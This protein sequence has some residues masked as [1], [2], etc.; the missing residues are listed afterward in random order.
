MLDVITKLRLQSLQD[1]MST[2]DR[3]DAETYNGLRACVSRNILRIETKAKENVTVNTG[4]L[5]NSI[6]HYQQDLSGYVK[7]FT[8]YAIDV[9]QGQKPGNM[10]SYAAIEYWFIRKNKL[11][12]KNKWDYYPRIQAIREKIYKDGTK[13]QPFLNPAFDGVVETFINECK[14]VANGA[15]D[16]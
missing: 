9:E 4:R 5:K 6:Q 8:N 13:A 11:R 2:V 14:E 15:W 1:W 10:P 7:A 16:N 12:M 3:R